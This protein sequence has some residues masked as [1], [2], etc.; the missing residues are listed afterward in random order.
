MANAIVFN[1][2]NVI[3]NN[4]PIINAPLNIKQPSLMELGENDIDQVSF[5][6]QIS[7]KADRSGSWQKPKSIDQPTAETAANDVLS[8]R[9]TSNVPNLTKPTPLVMPQVNIVF[10]INT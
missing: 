8:V 4:G 10:K 9:V 3:N 6:K 2:N 5:Y 7:M 1:S